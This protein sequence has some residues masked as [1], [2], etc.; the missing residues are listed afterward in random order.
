MNITAAKLPGPFPNK[1][2]QNQLLNYLS[3][4]SGTPGHLDSSTS[5]EELPM[6]P[7]NKRDRQL[8]R[9]SQLSRE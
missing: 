1:P 2:K 8:H 9:C 3:A 6:T 7:Q 4:N 5:S